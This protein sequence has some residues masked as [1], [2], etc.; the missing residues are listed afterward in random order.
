MDILFD[1]GL[2]MV[3]ATLA[4]FIA[5]LLK[6]PTIPAYV[7][8]GVLLGPIL[9][10][11]KDPSSIA[12]L[13][14][15]G[16]AFLLF[17]VGLEL[18]LRKLKD[19]G[20]VA[21]VGGLLRT[22]ALFLS[23][24]FAGLLFGFTN[25]QAVYTGLILSFSSTM[26]VI[27]L[28]SD[29]HELDTLHGRIVIGTLLLQDIIAILALSMLGT[30][31]RGGFSD[32]LVSLTS[33]V[34]LIIITFFAGKAFF[35]I[36]FR[37]AA[38]DVELLFLMAVS[39]C[40][41]MSMIF[42]FFGFS[43][44]VGAFVA[45]VILGNLPYNIE[46]ISKINPLKDFFSVLFFSSMGLELQLI[47]FT[48]ILSPLLVLIIIVMVISP[49]ITIIITSL[50]GYKKR[51][52]FLTGISL[53][54]ISAFGLIIVNQGYILGHVSDEFFGLTLLLALITMTLT[55]YLLAF[56]D[57]IY[58]WFSK[59]LGIFEKLS[60]NTKEL[61]NLAENSKHD[62]ILVGFDRTGY[63]ILQTLRKLKN[64]FIVVDFDPDVIKHLIERKIP[65]IYGDIGDQEILRRLKLH[66]VNM[67]ISTVP[68]HHENLLLLET[69]KKHN[70]HATIIVTSYRSDEALELYEKGASYV[71]IPHFLGGEHVSI[72]LESVSNDLDKLIQTKLTHI[73]ELKE[74][75]EI[76]PKK[77][78]FLGSIKK[79]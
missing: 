9:G 3:L 25:L 16:I 57:N 38:E 53:A 63:S 62:V 27:K 5:K 11:I 49:L 60:K 8:T 15:I 23:G 76:R 77:T 31:G 58:D 34:G 6:Q 35:P 12:S 72:M 68:N 50:F 7:L 52:S 73:A 54:Q 18:D 67:I 61:H 37:K 2:I 55:T 30:V 1:I 40:L 26:V 39:V 79:H 21:L 17:I 59:Y 41:F 74:R 65:C 22:A 43:I 33:G 10:L 28:L 66:Q 44:V 75:E 46:I 4:G 42:T 36:L 13:S 47:D 14:E 24:Y 70:K 29:K 56:D 45:G 20:N 51:T 69:I 71:I 48:K 78:R 32:A 19:T 64:D